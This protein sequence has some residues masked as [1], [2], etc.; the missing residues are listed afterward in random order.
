[1]IKDFTYLHNN[2]PLDIRIDL[3]LEKVYLKWRFLNLKETSI[4]LS[5]LSE[6]IL[7]LQNIKNNMYE[8]KFTS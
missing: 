6:F 4:N 3:N 8:Q 2:T 5:E 7:I 1:M